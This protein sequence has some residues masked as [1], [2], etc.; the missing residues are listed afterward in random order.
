MNELCR[1]MD[2]TM[3]Q[4]QAAED[5]LRHLNLHPS[6]AFATGTEIKSDEITPDFEVDVDDTNGSISITLLNRIPELQISESYSSMYEQFEKVKPRTKREQEQAMI[7]RK[8]YDDAGNFLRLVKMRQETLFATMRSIVKHQREFF[9]SGDESDLN[10]LT[11]KQ[12]SAD[13][14]YDES[15]LSRATTN[16][17]VWT[18]RGVYSLKFFFHGKMKQGDDDVT[19]LELQNV[20]KE[21][22]DAE[23]KTRPL[24]DEQITIKLT[25]RGYSIKR[26]TVAKY[27]ELLKI[28]VARMRRTVT[29][30]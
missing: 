23:D 28:P 12:V 22:V 24:S 26:R 10:P 6:S 20:I 18:R 21:L 3:E 16:K 5:C 8:S 9:L 27:R 15:V 25:S 2:I 30:K 4:Y 11:L 14:G 7:I 13:T 1:A 19:P 29:S 17:Y